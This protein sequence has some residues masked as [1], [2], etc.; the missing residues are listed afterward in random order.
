MR[1]LCSKRARHGAWRLAT[2]LVL[3]RPVAGFR[4]AFDTCSLFEA[5]VERG[6]HYRTI[7]TYLDGLI[8]LGLHGEVGDSKLD[9]LREMRFV[10]ANR[11]ARVDKRKVARIADLEERGGFM[12]IAEAIG[13]LRSAAKGLPAWSAAAE[14]L[15]RAAAVLAVEINAFRPDRIRRVM[16]PRRG[17]RARALGRVAARRG[18]R[19]RPASVKTSASSGKRLG[20]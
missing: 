4:S 9:G 8:G 16:A 3:R 12:V 1:Q 20:R 6:E 15:R 14:R 11:A 19:A 18:P 2:G 13:R 10:A 5:L 17:A 7:G